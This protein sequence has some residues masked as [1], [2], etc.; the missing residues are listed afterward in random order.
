[1]YSYVIGVDK[2]IFSSTAFFIKEKF[3]AI[4]PLHFIFCFHRKQEL[5]FRPYLSII[6]I[7]LP[8]LWFWQL[9]MMPQRNVLVKSITFIMFTCI[10]SSFMNNVIKFS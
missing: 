6:G 10:T 8:Q 9:M 1:M 5:T 3:A 4:Y 2:V 7:F